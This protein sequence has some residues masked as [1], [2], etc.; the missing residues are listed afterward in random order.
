MVVAILYLARLPKKQFI[1]DFNFH[2]GH[3]GA[4]TLSKKMWI[5]HVIH[6]TNESIVPNL[7][8]NLRIASEIEHI[9]G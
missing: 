7:S 8:S 1:S 6:K 9:L 3:N 2:A 4:K 5:P